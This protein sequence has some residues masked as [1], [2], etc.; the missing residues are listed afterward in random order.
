MALPMACPEISE[1]ESLV[2]GDLPSGDAD[3]LTR[4]LF[5]CP[6]CRGLRDELTEN[7][8]IE[9][10]VRQALQ[11]IPTAGK[12][13]PLPAQIGPYRILRE[14]GRGGMGIVYEA[15][16]QNPRRHVAVQNT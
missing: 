6:P 13:A 9:G 4:H 16:Q 2:A 7:L 5:D 8:R 11:R 12:A 15:E 1:L 14:I 3:V 10:S